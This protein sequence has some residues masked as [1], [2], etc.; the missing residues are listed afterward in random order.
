[1]S[2]SIRTLV[3]TLLFALT[4]SAAPR[5]ASAVSYGT[6]MGSAD[7][8]GNGTLEQVYNN[9]SSIKVVS[10]TSVTTYS[11]GFTSWAL[12]YGDFSS[13]VDLDGQPGAEIAVNVGSSLKVIN[14][15]LRT[16][17][18]Y[19]MPATWAAAPGGI[20]DLDGTAG[21]EI[22]I[23]TTSGLRLVTERTHT[24]RDVSIGG[25][26]A[27]ISKGIV[28]L[29]GTRGAEIPVASGPYLKVY[30]MRR[31]SLQTFTISTG[32][33][34]VCTTGSACVSDLDGDPGNELVIISGSELK[35]LSLYSTGG[36]FGSFLHSYTI[37][38]QFAIL[39]NGV[40]QF[41]SSVGNDIAISRN[42]GRLLVL[43]P[44]TGYLQ[45]INGT[46]TFGSS[47]SLLGYINRSG[48]D[49]IRVHSY[50]NNRNYVVDP[51]TGSILAE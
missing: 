42:D 43:Y 21:A 17:S 22:T 36:V 30:N 47:W 44:R 40:R 13:V 12:L 41:N 48:G 33:W 2:I 37:G 19:S 50:V 16:M 1:M 20:T 29:D 6:L 26:F 38:Q 8:D 39:S 35:V 23:I 28:D 9:L 10:G 45:T 11:L 7:L 3:S 14:H 15:R 34:A 24:T 49:Q 27:V 51:R 18:T 25:Q 4:L 31:A 5:L 32:S 46:G